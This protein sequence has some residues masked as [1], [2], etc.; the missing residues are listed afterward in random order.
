ML[1]I[2]AFVNMVITKLI[3]IILASCISDG[4]EKRCFFTIE[5]HDGK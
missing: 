5:T 4:R 3:T 1:M 2:Y